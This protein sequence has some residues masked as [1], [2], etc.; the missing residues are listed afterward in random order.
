MFITFFKVLASKRNL[1]IDYPDSEEI[2]TKTIKNALS[3]YKN[4]GFYDTTFPAVVELTFYRTDMCDSVFEN[5][6][7]NVE[8]VDARTLRKVINKLEFYDDLKF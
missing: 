1:A 8:R 5:C 3:D 7:V 6:D 2:I 4:I